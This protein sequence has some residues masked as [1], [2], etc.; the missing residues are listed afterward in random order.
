MTP[1]HF[2][3]DIQDLLLQLAKHRVRY[4]IVGA[5]AVIFHGFARLTGDVDLFFEPTPPNC[6]ALFSALR[7]FWNGPVPGIESPADLATKGTIFQF[8]HPPNRIDLM[9]AISGVGFSAAWK[10]KTPQTIL[11]RKKKITIPYIGLLALIKN[12]EACGRPKD[13]EDLKY[14]REAARLSRRRPS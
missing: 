8:G 10:S 2:S 3:P 11:I 7:D 1:P 4:L 5:E 12:K 14:L 6:R 9:N 13:L